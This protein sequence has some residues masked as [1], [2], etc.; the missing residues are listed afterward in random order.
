MMYGVFSSV[1]D[2]DHTL[3]RDYCLSACPTLI[4][5]TAWGAFPI[6]S[7]LDWD[8]PVLAV[9]TPSLTVEMIDPSGSLSVIPFYK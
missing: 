2:A 1:S 3:R 5:L 9:L 4:C 8:S 6:S 7:R